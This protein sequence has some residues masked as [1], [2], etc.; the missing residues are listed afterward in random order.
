MLGKTGLTAVEPFILPKNYHIGVYGTTQEPYT[1][2]VLRYAI[3][4]RSLFSPK[5]A[6]RRL[7]RG[8][9]GQAELVRRCGELARGEGV[10]GGP[11]DFI[12]LREKDLRPD[13]IVH[14]GKSVLAAIR[15]GGRHTRLLVNVDNDLSAALSIGAD[16]VHL[17]SH[18]QVTPEAVRMRF[19]QA[20]LAEPVITVSCHTTQEVMRARRWGV[21]AALYGPV[22]G[23]T[24]Q[25][26]QVQPGVGLAALEQ[27]CRMAWPLPVLALG[28]V[29]GANAAECM[30]AGAAGVAAIRMFMLP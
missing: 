4:D 8:N 27:A 22:Y 6:L 14:L 26:E 2:A 5:Y 9:E 12:Q 25:G 10:A 15:A 11:V 20:G 28:G 13:E 23:K 7:P 1:G 17:T 19:R 24:V 30:A 18:A 16:G 29:T 3:T 21:T